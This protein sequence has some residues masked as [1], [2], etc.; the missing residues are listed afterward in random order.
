VSNE[1]G[2]IKVLLAMF[3]MTIVILVLAGLSFDL[4]KKNDLLRLD[5]KRLKD[6]QV[7]LMVPDEHAAAIAHWLESNPKQTQSFINMATKPSKRMQATTPEQTIIESIAEPTGDEL[8]SE[9]EDGVKVI[10]LPHGGIRVTTRDETDVK[11]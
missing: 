10:K 1:S 8:V 3:L 4:N 2:G 9:S 11:Q 6:S 7:L 5:V